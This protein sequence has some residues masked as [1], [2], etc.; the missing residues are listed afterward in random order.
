MTALEAD[1]PSHFASHGLCL[2]SASP[3][4]FSLLSPSV[5]AHKPSEGLPWKRHDGCDAQKGAAGRDASP[6][7]PLGETSQH[8]HFS[9]FPNW[10]AQFSPTFFFFFTLVAGPRRSLSLKLSDTSVY[11][12]QIRARLGTTADPPPTSPCPPSLTPPTPRR[13]AEAV[14]IFEP[15]KFP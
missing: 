15:G 2:G 10:H 7:G 3:S 11:E 5:W 14:A 4:S 13:Q 8:A 1:C 9:L 12:P 6:G